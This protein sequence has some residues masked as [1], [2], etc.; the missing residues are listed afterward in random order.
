M[1]NF[2]FLPSMLWH[3]WLGVANSIRRVKSDWWGVGVVVYLKRGADCLHIVQLMPRHP[4]TPSSLASFK[5]TGL[6]FLVPAYS[7]Y[8][9]TWDAVLTCDQKADMRQLNL[10]HRTKT[11]KWKTEKL[12]VKNHKQLP[13]LVLE[14]RPLNGCSSCSSSLC[15]FQ[16]LVQ[17]CP[18]FVI[19]CCCCCCVQL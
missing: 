14:K 9:M 8:D 5:S 7:A 16:Y 19:I 13:Q 11:K 4:K 10:P 15:F 6:T 3:C 18:V 12:K 1:A 17:W 2:T